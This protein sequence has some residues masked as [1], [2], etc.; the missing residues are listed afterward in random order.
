MKKVKEE[1]AAAGEDTKPLEMP[2]E[3]A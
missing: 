2:D 1:K 3:E